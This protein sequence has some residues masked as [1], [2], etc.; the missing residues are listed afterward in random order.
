MNI[1]VHFY[2]KHMLYSTSL[3]ITL[4]CELLYGNLLGVGRRTETEKSRDD[5]CTRIISIQIAA[6]VCTLFGIY[7]YPYFLEQFIV[8]SCHHAF[9]GRPFPENEY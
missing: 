7:C 3:V 1:Y 2:H 8:Y 9:L 4:P 6:M 5:H